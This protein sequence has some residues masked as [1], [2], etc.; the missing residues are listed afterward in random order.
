VNRAVEPL[1][2]SVDTATDV[3]SVVVVR[4]TRLLSFKKGAG[5]NTHSA[6]ILSEIDEALRAADVGVGEI[7]LFAVASGPGSFT[8]LRAGLATIKSFASTLQRPTVGVPTLHAVA[9]AAGESRR[10]VAAIPAGRGELFAQLLEVTSDGS[11]VELTKPSHVAPAVLLDKMA[12]VGTSLRWTGEG[13]HAHADAISQQAL[14][15]G[16]RFVVE[17]E[18]IMEGGERSWTLAPRTNVLAA[19]VAAL[20]LASFRRGHAV[21]AVELRA[22]YV[23]ASDAE[24]NEQCRA[25]NQS[26]K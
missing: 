20:A 18:Q 23:R 13:A 11:I 3:R 7:E 14:H 2:L 10:V 16:L 8:G 24:I 5:R 17:S 15:Q 1:I 21:R 6:S 26:S 22:I 19:H 4:G 9:H 12:A 25:P